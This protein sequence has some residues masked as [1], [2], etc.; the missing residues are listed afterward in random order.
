MRRG[1]FPRARIAGRKSM[2]LS[3]EVQAWLEG[4]PVRKLKGDPEG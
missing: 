3:S 2:W 4:L 1:K